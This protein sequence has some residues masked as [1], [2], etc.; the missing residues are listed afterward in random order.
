MY[1][2]HY[3]LALKQTS[4]CVFV[5]VFVVAV[6]CVYVVF[7]MDLILCLTPNTMTVED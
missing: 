4:L 2:F 3:H 7:R 5:L 6:L 1:K